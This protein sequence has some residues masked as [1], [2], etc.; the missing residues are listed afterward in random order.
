MSEASEL[1]PVFGLVQT[2]C[3]GLVVF[4]VTRAIN[5]GLS[6]LGFITLIFVT[7]LGYFVSLAQMQWVTSIVWFGMFISVIFC[8]TRLSQPIDICFSTISAVVL[9][10]ALLTMNW[11]IAATCGL[12]CY[13]LRVLRQWRLQPVYHDGPD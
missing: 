7:F 5:K 12:L 4:F 1:Y 3:F 11:Q 9:I 2:I 8:E 13:L 6:E 10:I